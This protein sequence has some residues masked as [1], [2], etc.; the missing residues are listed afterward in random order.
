M[1]GSH[2][3]GFDGLK[4]L[5][6]SW[7]SSSKPA[8]VAV[9]LALGLG[10]GGCTPAGGTSPGQPS[11]G[12]SESGQSSPG[13]SDPTGTA[14]PASP[15]TSEAPA[16]VVP[17]SQ[18]NPRPA[19]QVAD[20]GTLRLAVPSLPADWN[21]WTSADPV[22][23][24]AAEWLS[25][26]LFT[27]DTTGAA[28]WNPDWLAGAPTLST[29]DP[30]VVEY[31]LNPAAVWSDGT[32]LSLADFVATW[33]VCRT[34][35]VQQCQGR[36]FD[37]VAAVTSPTPDVVQVTYDRA[38]ADWATTY[39]G[40]LLR[41]GAGTG[42]SSGTTPAGS[43]AW[44]SLAAH[45]AQ[46]AGPFRYTASTATTVTFSRNPFWW[47]TPPKLDAIQLVVVPDDQLALA[48]ANDQIDAFWVDQANTYA[49]TQGS[50]DLQVRVAP[51]PASRW[52]AFNCAA[53]ALSDRNVRQAL[54]RGIDR[55]TVA[56][57][58]LAGLVWAGQSLNNTIFLP[59]QAGYADLAK[60]TAT[61]VD[62]A[63]ANAALDQAGYELVDGQ[64]R[65]DG[66]ALV[67]TFLVQ[68]GDALAENEAFS[69]RAQLRGL[70]VGL[71]VVYDAPADLAADLA[72]GHYDLTALTWANPSPLAAAARLAAPNPW[73]Y[74]NAV[75]DALLA[76]APGDF[77]P[78]ARATALAAVAVDTWYDPPL[79]PLYQVPQI[80]MTRPAL[81][82]YGPDGLATTQ[83]ATVGWT[84]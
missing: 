67:L 49:Q 19:S 24:L 58:D 13:Q 54:L 81:A 35:S 75:V 33:Q 77:D 8:V 62:L 57:A 31:Q 44:D 82:N 27:T 10:L 17:G 23:Q 70:G 30:T 7:L 9:I 69:V 14:T 25:P 41:A 76:A 12:H 3:G 18:T 46:T 51:G 60:T 72:A 68:Q 83:W 61:G 55:L 66:T 45:T 37:H 63:A 64:R 47:G 53:G 20:G 1:R 43:A 11:P 5:V 38:W 80:L 71:D 28:Q 21:P 15:V 50:G 2:G 74:D 22:A 6:H 73:G 59:G 36:G 78:G 48:Y 84:A 79:L 39:A 40:G 34:S 65:R 4:H 52:L 16:P 29:T 56:N 42:A 26:R 32:A